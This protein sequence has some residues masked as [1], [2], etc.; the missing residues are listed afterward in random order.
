MK[1]RDKGAKIGEGTH[2]M[3]R[4]RRRRDGGTAGKVKRD[5]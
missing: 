1:E 3:E 2:S 5:G 4:R